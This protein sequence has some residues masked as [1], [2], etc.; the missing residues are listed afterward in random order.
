MTLRRKS[1]FVISA[2]LAGIVLLLFGVSQAILLN[3]Y[4]LLEE[5]AVGA[6]TGRV[7]R[8]LNEYLDQLSRTTADWSYWN[9]TY[10][11]ALGAYD[12][13]QADNANLETLVNL[14]LNFIIGWDREGAV[15]FHRFIDLEEKV[16]SGPG[17]TVDAAF[18]ELVKPAPEDLLSHVTGIMKVDGRALLLSSRH[19][20]DSQYDG[21]SA[22]TFLFGVYLNDSRTAA[23]EE[24]VLSQITFF[25]VDD[26]ALPVAE[27]AVLGALDPSG[28]VLVQPQNRETVSGYQILRDVRGQP[29]YLLKVD[30]P[31]VLYRQGLSSLSYFVN[32]LILFGVFAIVVTLLLLDRLVLA[33]LARLHNDVTRIRQTGDLSLM[34][35]ADGRDE[36]AGLGRVLNALFEEVAQTREQLQH[37]NRELEKRVVERT[38]ALAE[39]NRTLQ[40]EVSQRQ[41]VEIKLAAARDQA[42]EALRLKAQILANVS[43]DARTP[44]NVIILRCEMLLHESAGPID[45]RQKKMMETILLSARE[46]LHFFTNLL[47]QSK[48]KALKIARVAFSPQELLEEVEILMQPL[49]GRKG[50]AWRCGLDPQ[51]PPT[52]VGDKERLKQ[53]LGNL[54]DNAIK[55]TDAGMIHLYLEQHDANTWAIIVSDTGC[56]IAAE[57]RSYIFDTFWQADGSPTRRVTRGVGLGL[58]IVKQLTVLMGGDVQVTANERGPGSTFVVKLPLHEAGTGKGTTHEEALEPHH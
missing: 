58:S 25:D 5:S 32:N 22:G 39:T 38:E 16:E 31:R 6:D 10:D 19:I 8:S 9:D 55:Y 42:V 35:E 18:L 36:I 20:L 2:T 12:D 56:G 29:V 44:L 30:T 21:P 4:R 27:Q 40:A 11:F 34:V 23:L 45:S 47:E 52:L 43:H 50:L 13:Y 33:R 14:D 49:A 3:S 7:V 46:L 57:D 1:F 15:F 51:L 48:G 41:Q 17:F 54:V 37:F 24:I 28:K 53:I 26:P